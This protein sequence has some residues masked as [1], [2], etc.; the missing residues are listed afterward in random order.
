MENL[1]RAGKDERWLKTVLA[2]HNSDI[3]STFLLTV[4]EKDHILWIGKET[5]DRKSVV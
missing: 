2:Q 1:R 3:A 5:T 4:D